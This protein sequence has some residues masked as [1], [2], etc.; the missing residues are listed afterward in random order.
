VTTREVLTIPGVAPLPVEALVD[1][2]GGG[3]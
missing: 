3:S 1:A 2:F